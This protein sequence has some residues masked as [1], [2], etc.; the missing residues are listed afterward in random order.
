MSTLALKKNVTRITLSCPLTATTSPRGVKM[1]FSSL[2][3]SQPSPLFFYLHLPPPRGEEGKRERGGGLKCSFSL[4]HFSHPERGEKFL[5]EEEEEEERDESVFYPS[6]SSSPS[7]LFLA[8]KNGG[9]DGFSLLFSSQRLKKKNQKKYLNIQ[10]L[11][12][13]PK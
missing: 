6:S 10:E 7:L 2:R 8:S 5:K 1:S 12:R 4:A 13:H 3:H 11:I 9:C